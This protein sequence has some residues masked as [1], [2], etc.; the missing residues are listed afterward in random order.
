MRILHIINNGTTRGGAERLAADLVG[1]Q[2][3]TGH[4]VHVLSS[5]LPDRGTWFA[6]TTFA[7]AGAS[8]PARLRNRFRNPAAATALAALLDEWRP[9]VV[10]LHTVGLLSPAALPLLSGV[11]TVLTVHGPELFLR[12]TVRQCLPASYFRGG[13]R[14]GARLTV[15]GR[16]AERW[17]TIVGRR[18]WCRALRSVDLFVAPSPYTAAIVAR[19][20]GE[21]RM[22]RNGVGADRLAAVPHLGGTGR[23]VTV[24]RLEDSKGPQVLLAALPAILAAHPGARLTVVGSGPM[25]A[26]LRE[27]A[28]RLAVAAAVD[29]AGWQAP[30][31]QAALLATADV[32]VVPAVSPESFGLTALEAQA[33]GCAVVAS[34]AGGLADVVRHGETGLLVP[35]GDPDALAAAVGRLLGDAALRDRLGAAGQRSAAELTIPAHAA[36]LLT[37]YREAIGRHSAAVIITAFSSPRRRKSGGDHQGAAGAPAAEVTA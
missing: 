3:A 26:E 4:A 31:E 2:R 6:D 36:A 34:A 35:P 32:A 22:V 25:E 10:H 11:P 27:L 20:L 28:R 23:I 16:L 12:E 15:R 7:V 17:E 1:E 9:D 18:L 29:F 14:I 24:G 21:T 30:A 8:L 5:D 37:V 13:H 33:A 19:A